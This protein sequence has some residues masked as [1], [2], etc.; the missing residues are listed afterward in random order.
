[1]QIKICKKLNYVGKIYTQ[2]FSFLHL[3]KIL[4][5]NLSAKHLNVENRPFYFLIT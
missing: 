3:D 1:M 5:K 2:M 4:Y